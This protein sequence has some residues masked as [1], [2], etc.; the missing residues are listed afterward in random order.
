MSV[1]SFYIALLLILVAFAL[2]FNSCEAPKYYD[3]ATATSAG[4]PQL[5]NLATG[6][7]PPA[8]PS[9]V[10]PALPTL[11][12]ALPCTNVGCLAP[13]FNLPTSDQ[14]ELTLSSL[15]GKKVVLAFF[16]TT[17]SA[18]IKAALCLL[19]LYA[20]WPRDQL[21]MV[22]VV[23]GEQF[24]DVQYWIN[25]YG[26]NCPVVLDSS[27]KVRDMYKPDQVP[28]L[29]FLS[30]ERVIKVREYSPVDSCTEQFNALLRQY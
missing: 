13:D 19:P 29:Y 30:S 17:C 23:S 9:S 11:M 8:V 14:K 12:L 24:D 7:L 22:F 20:S 27:G 10:P 26:I 25:T 2:V 18:C 21:E 15:K 3:N 1:K 6:P 4:R 5:N 28:A 16:S